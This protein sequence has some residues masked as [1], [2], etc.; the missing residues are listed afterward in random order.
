MKR[1]CAIRSLLSRSL[2]RWCLIARLRYSH[3]ADSDADVETLSGRCCLVRSLLPRRLRYSHRAD[4]DADDDALSG[5]CSLS[6]SLAR[7]C[8]VACVT[9]TAM[10]VTPTSMRYPAAAVS[11][12]RSLLPRRRRYF[13]RA[14]SDAD[15][16]SSRCGLARCLSPCRSALLSP[17]C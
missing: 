17:R 7:W 13:H 4:S 16:L 3:R 15:A 14:V 10:I 8:L 1:R 12:A 2:A 6:R 11:L 9:L 5:R